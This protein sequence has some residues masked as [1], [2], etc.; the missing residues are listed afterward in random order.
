MKETK[1]NN[2][3]KKERKVGDGVKGNTIRPWFYIDYSSFFITMSS[4][5]RV[6]K[7]KQ[8]N[9]TVT[10]KLEMIRELESGNLTYRTAQSLRSAGSTIL[11]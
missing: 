5:G 4:T 11:C 1:V 2:G 3:R 7:L 9:L 10:Q 6:E 8:V